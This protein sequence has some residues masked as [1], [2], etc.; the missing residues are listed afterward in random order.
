MMVDGSSVTCT[1]PTFAFP[2]S[3]YAGISMCTLPVT[4]GS[5]ALFKMHDG[6]ADSSFRL[7]A[8][9]VTAHTH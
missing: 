2:A 3:C 1:A 6:G 9:A 5:Q 4:A 8:A 7:L